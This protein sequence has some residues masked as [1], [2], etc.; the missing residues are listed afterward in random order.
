M[1]G[2]LHVALVRVRVCACMRVCPHHVPSMALRHLSLTSLSLI[3]LIKTQS[4][5]AGLQINM[6]AIS[7]SAAGSQI[8]RLALWVSDHVLKSPGSGKTLI[9]EACCIFLHVPP[10]PPHHPSIY[11]Y[12]EC[13]TTRHSQTILWSLCVGR[14]ESESFTCIVRERDAP[15]TVRVGVCTWCLWPVASL[16]T[17][18][19]QLFYIFTIQQFV[20]MQQ[21][22]LLWNF[23]NKAH[24]GNLFRG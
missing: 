3:N 14:G 20:R 9:C 11:L 17:S 19:H 21:N 16:S 22:S 8:T 18:C 1:V 24:P 12:L 15:Q 5:S 2:R 6:V 23:K 4:G 13:T 10:P 7:P